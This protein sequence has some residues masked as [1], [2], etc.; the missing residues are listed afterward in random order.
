MPQLPARLA[1]LGFNRNGSRRYRCTQCGK[2]FTDRGPRP[3]GDM[4]LEFD[5]GL[6]PLQ[7]L[8]EGGSIRSAERITGVPRNTIMSL[9]VEA[10][11]NA[12]RLLRTR[13]RNVPVTD[14]QADEIWGFVQKK[15]GHKN[16]LEATAPT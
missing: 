4:Y 12:E 2:T 7:I 3:Y 15:E 14:V 16:P 6:M 5:R 1:P 10:G 13:V 9:I 8:V 11:Q